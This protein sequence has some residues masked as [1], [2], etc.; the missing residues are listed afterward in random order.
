MRRLAL[1]LLTA[2][3]FA[4]NTPKDLDLTA[5]DG[6]KLRATYYAAAK[7]GPGVLLLHMCNTTRKSWEPVAKELSH[8][9]I[10]ALTVDNRGFGESGDAASMT[11]TAG[12]P[13]KR[14][15]MPASIRR[16]G[17]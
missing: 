2:S 13:K 3:A 10:N 14:R 8:S 7:P 17:A 15:R 6:T 12:L 4:Q 16:S 1:L 9:G 11:I 5:P